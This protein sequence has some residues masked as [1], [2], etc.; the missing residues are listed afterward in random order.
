MQPLAPRFSTIVAFDAAR[1]GFAHLHPNEIDLTKLP[2]PAAP[3]LTFMI[4]IPNPGLYVIWAQ[5]NIGGL[6]EF[7]P[8]WF[9]VAP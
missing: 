3:R 7:V 4:T 5:L 1:S 9:E 8:F 6:E 2:D